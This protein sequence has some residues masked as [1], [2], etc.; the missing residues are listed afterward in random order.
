MNG[1]SPTHTRSRCV[2]RTTR[3]PAQPCGGTCDQPSTVALGLVTGPSAARGTLVRDPVHKGHSVI[4]GIH[5]DAVA[6]PFPSRLNIHVLTF[7]VQHNAAA[8]RWGALPRTLSLSSVNIH[9]PLFRDLKGDTLP[10]VTCLPPSEINGRTPSPLP[11]VHPVFLFRS[12]GTF[13]SVHHGRGL[14]ATSLMHSPKLPTQH[15]KSAS[16]FVYHGE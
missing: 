6:L 4:H 8:T 3:P 10:T 12:Q 2:D 15:R 14:A 1:H 5:T 16:R 11:T 9:V 7:G 13:L